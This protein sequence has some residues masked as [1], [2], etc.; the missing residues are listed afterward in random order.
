MQRKIKLVIESDLENIPLIGTAINKLCS[1]IPL[2]DEEAFQMELC[3]V[4]AVTNSIKHAYGYDSEHQVEIN[5]VLSSEEL[6]VDICDKGRPLDKELMEKKF[7]EPLEFDD[8]DLENIPEG[9]R[10]L[11][12]INTIMDNVSYRSEKG[13]NCLTMK[14]KFNLLVG[15]AKGPV[16]GQ[17]ENGEE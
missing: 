14:K 8:T 11:A 15:D 9:G 6:T 7:R 3:V 4:E 12:I 16:N 10:G 2:S 17:T 1:L 5:F 13:I